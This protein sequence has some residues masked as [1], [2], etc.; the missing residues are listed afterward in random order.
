MQVIDTW[1]LIILFFLFFIC[2]EISI[3]KGLKKFNIYLRFGDYGCYSKKVTQNMTQNCFL[4]FTYFRVCF[5]KGFCE[6]VHF[7]ANI[8]S[9][10]YLSITSFIVASGCLI[11]TSNYSNESK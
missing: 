6:V 1:G 5:L 4:Y 9:S 8:K 7:Q 2:L 3:A 11:Y 10:L